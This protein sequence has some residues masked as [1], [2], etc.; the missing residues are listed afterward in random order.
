M[1]EIEGRWARRRE[2]PD[3]AFNL[4]TEVDRIFADDDTS[5]Q[6]KYDKLQA[7]HGRLAAIYARVSAIDRELEGL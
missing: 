4:I 3:L 5:K 7:L 2:L 6:D 1:M